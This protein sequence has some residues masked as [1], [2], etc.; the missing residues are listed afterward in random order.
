MPE[1]RLHIPPAVLQFFEIIL[2]MKEFLMLLK[3]HEE[4]KQPPT[5]SGIWDM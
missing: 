4:P 3:L 5:F 2:L 1:L